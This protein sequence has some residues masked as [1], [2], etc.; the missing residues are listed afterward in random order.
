MMTFRIDH[1]PKITALALAP[2]AN[3][4]AEHFRRVPEPVRGELLNQAEI[5]VF[6]EFY[7]MQGCAKS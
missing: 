5:R 3:E 4:G 6:F 2:Q 1:A 7:G